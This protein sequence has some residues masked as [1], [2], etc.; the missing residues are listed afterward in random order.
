M[1]ITPTEKVWMNGRLVDW[2]D[3][4]IH[5]LTHTLHYGTGVFEGMRCYE[6]PDGP[7][8]FRLT[9]HM[10]RLH[11]SARILMMPLPYTVEEL[12]QAAKDTVRATGLPSCYVRPIAYYGFGEM[13]V[14]TLNC[15]V[16]VAIACW[17][18]G[19]YLGEEALLKGAKMKVA[20]WTRHDHNTMPPAAK[21]TGNYVNSSLAK[22]EAIKAGYDEA[23]M[24]NPQGFVSECTGENLFVS[25][26]GKLITP[27][28][29]AGALE[30]IT[31]SSVMSIAGDLGFDV[32]VDYLARSDLYIADEIFL[33]GTAAEVTP[34]SSVDDRA[35][36]C[37]GPMTKAVM[38]EYGKAVRG[39]V[40]RYKDWVEHV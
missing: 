14:S 3:A 38:E 29:A 10:L 22:V 30:G 16:D 24:L 33:C 21:T 20:S 2:A 27:P 25:R 9:D 13:G 17:P 35:V 19:A 5:I 31:Q 18:W 15:T 12:V 34:V 28:L 1:P 6:T 26:Q 37:P 11:Q 36:P 32:S 40:D 39:Q 7:A 8:I 4:K 23:I